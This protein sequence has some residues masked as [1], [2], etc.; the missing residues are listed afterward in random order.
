MNCDFYDP[1]GKSFFQCSIE[2][3]FTAPIWK[4]FY[5]FSWLLWITIISFLYE[6]LRCARC[7][8]ESPYPILLSFL[9]PSKLFWR[10][11]IQGTSCVGSSFFMMIILELREVSLS[12]W[13]FA[14]TLKAFL[15]KLIVYLVM[16]WYHIDVK[17]SKAMLLLHRWLKVLDDGN[18]HIVLKLCKPGLLQVLCKNCYSRNVPKWHEWY[19][20]ELLWFDGISLQ[21]CIDISKLM[22]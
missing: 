20:L 5:L 17:N 21:Q 3:I 8:A 9:S 7:A 15:T 1:A 2:I 19:Q 18:F 13:H 16:L 6:L 11:Q 10:L 12:S 14:T 22:S 4:S